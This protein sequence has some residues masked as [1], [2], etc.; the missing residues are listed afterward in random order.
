MLVVVVVVLL[1]LLLLR[2]HQVVLSVAEH[3][4]N[5][6]P[7]QMVAARTG[8]VL[9]HVRLTPDTQELDMQVCAVLWQGRWLAGRCGW[10]SELCSL[11][12]AAPR[13]HLH[14]PCAHLRLTC[15]PPPTPRNIAPA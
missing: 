9:K 1:L 13:P 3:H 7:W 10:C 12:L 15:A 6:V 2:P 8:A 14:A 4:S 11:I 5:L